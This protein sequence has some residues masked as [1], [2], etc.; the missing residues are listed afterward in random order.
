MG[1]KWGCPPDSHKI[2]WKYIVAA[3]PQVIVAVHPQVEYYM[4]SMKKVHEA[5]KK[6][7]T[8]QLHL[9]TKTHQPDFGPYVIETPAVVVR[10]NIF[11]L[12]L[13]A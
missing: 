13:K 12:Q 2:S 1:K 4:N 10:D 8:I 9:K 6:I 5:E 7:F 3:H 11:Y